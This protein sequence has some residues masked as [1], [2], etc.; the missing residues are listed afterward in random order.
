MQQAD[1][2]AMRAIS[3]LL[4]AAASSQQKGHAARL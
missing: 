2:G 4:K 1:Q 3:T